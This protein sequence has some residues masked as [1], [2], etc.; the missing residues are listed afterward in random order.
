[1]PRND[2]DPP[3]QQLRVLLADRD[4]IV[5]RTVRDVLRGQG[6][7]VV[8][9][10]GD[11]FEAVSLAMDHKPDIVLIDVVLPELDGPT[12]IRRIVSASPLV[13]VVVFTVAKESD[14]AIVA[15]KAGA[16]GYITK[17]VDLSSLPRILRAVADGEA[18]I[19]RAFVPTLIDRLRAAPEGHSG[20]RPVRSTLTPREWEVLDLLSDGLTMDDVTDK[21]VLSSETVRS[22]LQRAMR[23]LGVNSRQAAI[24]EARRL[25][26]SAAD[27]NGSFGAAPAA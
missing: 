3:P 21:L 14:A 23:K 20:L 13:R 16:S 5:R 7:T 9:E 6:V 27:A 25:R 11:G 2:Q 1:M 19:S 24:E 26:G 18:A 17:D 8:A 15:L 12:A 4:P 22:H 10:A